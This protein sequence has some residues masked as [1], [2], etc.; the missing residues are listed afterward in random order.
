MAARRSS[1]LPLAMPGSLQ[2]G[3]ILSALCWL[4]FVAPH[5]S[6][7]EPDDQAPLTLCT[8]PWVPYFFGEFNQP[9]THGLGVD[10]TDALSH[11]AKLP[12]TIDLQPWNR[13]LHLLE[14][15]RVDGLILV[16]KNQQRLAKMLYSDMMMP[17]RNLLWFKSDRAPLQW[18]KLEQLKPLRIGRTRG[19][20]YGNDFEQDSQQLGL[21]FVLTNT[22]KQGFRMLAGGR[23][24]TF[25]ASE[26]SAR[27]LI[28][29]LDMENAF[30]PAP[31]PVSESLH[32]LAI[33]KRS[34]R[35]AYLPQI[36]NA[37]SELHAEG[38]IEQILQQH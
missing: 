5:S 18:Q 3:A 31:K 1:N 10:L 27:H 9:P 17:V 16:S 36:N 28:K 25:L 26:L 37:L 6:A 2:A 14:N 29:E 30:H 22:E 15:Q 35:T 34:P 20:G 21:T 7:A 23:F 32:Y 13:C 8:D 33:D 12:I 38:V 19:Y 24:D 4:L 11:R